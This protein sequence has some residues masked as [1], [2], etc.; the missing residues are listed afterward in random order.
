MNKVFRIGTRESEL[1]LWQ[2][3]L[4]KNMLLEVGYSSTLVLI[5]SEGDIDLKTPLYEMGV[6]G[7][8]TRSLD[9]ALINDTIDIAVHSMK[10]VP[11]VM[12]KGITSGA[13][14]KRGNYRD[15][16]IVNDKKYLGRKPPLGSF[17]PLRLSGDYDLLGDDL[18]SVAT[19]ATGSIRRKAQWLH[20]FP[21]H[22]IVN[23]RGNVNSRIKKISDSDWDGAIM[24]AAGVERINLRPDSAVELDWMLPAPAQGA[25]LA[26]CKINDE[27]S[28]NALRK[29]NDS[30]T[31]MAVNLER[32][33]LRALMGGCSTPISA[34]AIADKNDIY[35]RG[36]ILTTDGKSKIEIE[37]HVSKKN[38]NGFG[39]RMGADILKDGGQEILNQITNG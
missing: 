15:L 17:S 13:V 20:R 39:L 27:D 11:T 35:F 6:Q 3:N 19:V 14:I 5:K 25:V 8:F 31:E 26:A 4:I 7:I 12:P 37:K 16:F 22:Q 38:L 21:D 32:E 36:S 9:I 24:A 23:L 33:F 1:A 28:L 2:A 29:L 34:L 18:H 10:D 30:D